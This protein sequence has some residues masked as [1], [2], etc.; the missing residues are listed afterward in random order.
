MIRKIDISDEST[1]Q[2]VHKLQNLAYQVEADLIKYDNIPY[3]TQGLSDLMQED[4]I[5]YAYKDDTDKIIGVISFSIVNDG[6]LDIHRFMVHPAHYRK[7]V[8][9]KLLR[10]VKSKYFLRKIIAQTGA[11]NRPAIEFYERNGIPFV[12]NIQVNKQIELA[13]FDVA[14]M[15]LEEYKEKVKTT[16]KLVE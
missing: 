8:A 12:C 16:D 15:S 10:H 1:A 5:F 2:Q 3:L 9:T 6:V 11:K 7:G 13:T 4:E 14:F